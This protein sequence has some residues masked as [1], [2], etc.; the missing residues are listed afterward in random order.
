MTFLPPRPASLERGSRA[1]RLWYL[2]ASI[3]AVALVAVSAPLEAVFYDVPVV[4]ALLLT[5]VQGAAL[6][7]AWRFPAA[8][9]GAFTVASFALRVFPAPAGPPWPWAV[10][11]IIA[12]ALLVG[13]VTTARGAWGGAAALLVPGLLV[14]ALALPRGDALADVIVALSIGAAAWVVGLLLAER[15]R[16]AG[17]L[18]RERET[19]AEEHERRLVAEE[20]QR[21][22]RELH[23]VV[24]H[25]LSLIQVQATSARYRL[26]ALPDEAAAEFDDIARSARTSLAEMRQLLGALRGDEPAALVPQPGIDDI[27]ALVAEARRAGAAIR[28]ER[29]VTEPVSTATGIAAY[30]IV[31]EAISNAVRHAPGTGVEARLWS[32]GTDLRLEITNSSPPAPAGTR[33]NGAGHGLIGMRERAAIL[34]GRLEARPTPSGGFR[35]AALLPLAP[36]EGS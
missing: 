27:P 13:I 7:A 12:L 17:Q 22:A 14:S 33:T 21:I 32:D 29:E 34:G 25:G 20:R 19:S 23:D 4:F 18:A 2:G 8:A 28:L 16:I 5:A 11:G 15:V 3:A 30:R 1:R 31:Q 6:V 26:A 35:V 9:V 36:R 24:A 10:T